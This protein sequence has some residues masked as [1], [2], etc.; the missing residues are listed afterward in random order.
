MTTLILAILVSIAVAYLAIQNTVNVPLQLGGFTFAQI[1]LYAVAI[2]AL[3]V[4]LLIGW[5][6]NLMQA[7]TSG[8]SIRKR[9]NT[10]RKT[11]GSLDQL[12][13]RINELEEENSHLKAQRTSTK[14]AHIER[15]PEPVV[16]HDEQK[17]H[18]PGFLEQIRHKISYR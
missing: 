3:L 10:I 18:R 14:D 1:P 7:I 9:E 2:G 15:D 4:G 5:I 13:A 8:M 11:Q 16:G 17:E 12:H 6:M